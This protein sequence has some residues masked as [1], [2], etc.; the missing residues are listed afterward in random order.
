M[1][2]GYLASLVQTNMV[3][4][5]A[6]SS[7]AQS[8]CFL[9]GI[10]AVGSNTLALQSV[11]VFGAAYVAMNLGAFAM[12]M[13]VGRNL[14]DFKGFGRTAPVAG[15]A[16][17]ILLLSLAGIP[18]LFGFV[19]KVLLFGAA[20]K[21]G[22]TWLA[23]IRHS[24]QCSGPGGP[25]AHHRTEVSTGSGRCCLCH[26]HKTAAAHL[27]LAGNSGYYADHGH[28]SSSVAL[29]PV[30][31]ACRTK[32]CCH[33]VP[34][35]NDW[36]FRASYRLLL[37]WKGNPEINEKHR[38]VG[39]SKNSAVRYTIVSGDLQMFFRVRFAEWENVHPISIAPYKPTQTA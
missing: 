27:C 1:T 29:R 15:V 4:L 39:Y 32:F 38:I 6:Y 24:Q 14:D 20:I 9:L 11:I 7:I 26:S 8:G 5:L 36:K 17:V 3:R 13:V 31:I 12:V 23:I 35:C 30:D 25:P 34:A 37:V 21:A 16:M 33:F 28:S 18:P 10:V 2:L 19:G 22:F